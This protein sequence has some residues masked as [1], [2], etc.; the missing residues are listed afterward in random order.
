MESN[1]M[2][3]SIVIPA[4]NEEKIIETLLRALHTQE[5]PAFEII[6]V[7][8]GSTDRTAKIARSCGARLLEEKRQGTLFARE[9]GRR[10][11]HGDIIANIDADCIP[12]PDWLAN[13]IEYFKDRDV[14]A[15]TGP[16]DYAD[17]SAF[18]RWLSWRVQKYIYRAISN[19][20][21]LRY[22]RCGAI[23]LGGN[24]LIRSDALSRIGGYDT[25]FEFYGDDTDTAKRLCKFGKV[26]FAP[27]VS[28]QTS[29]RRFR[30]NGILKTT[31]LYVFH[32]F[33]VIARRNS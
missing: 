6:V 13:G 19:F 31:W 10:E 32:F 3:V 15:V 17:A 25:S 30:K 28:V 24:V 11:A 12:P 23:I 22:I 8:N 9:G 5:Y 20:L 33:R 4:H 27:D 29:A 7:D 2:K 14:V 26:V 16:C 1:P 21:Q 18:F